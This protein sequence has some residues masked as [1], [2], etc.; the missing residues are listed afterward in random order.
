MSGGGGWRRVKVGEAVEEACGAGGGGWRVSGGEWEGHGVVLCWRGGRCAV[1]GWGEGGGG[2]GRREGWCWVSEGGLEGGGEGV[3]FA[4][5]ARGGG[6]GVE[7][8]HVAEGEG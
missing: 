5:G 4:T 2:R 3:E 8:W 1:Q 7:L 6:E